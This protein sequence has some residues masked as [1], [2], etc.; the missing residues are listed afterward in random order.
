MVIEALARRDRLVTLGG[1]LLVAG[2][3]WVCLLVGVAKG[4]VV[5]T[6]PM[7][8]TLDHAATT[9]LKWWVTMM[10][11]MLP[12]AAPMILLVA[13]VHRRRQPGRPDAAVALVAAGY[14]AVWGVFSL[15]AT[16]V[17]WCLERTGLLAPSTMRAVPVLAG[18]ILLG[19][20]LYQ[21][22]PLKG[23]CLRH[24]HAPLG[25]VSAHWR[26]GPSG[27]LRLGLRHG[28]FCLGCCWPLVALLFVVGAADLFWLGAL[29]LYILAEKMLP[30]GRLISLL[31]GCALTGAGV[32]VLA[33]A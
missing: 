13:A 26:R 9:F 16:G 4:W 6:T 10:A 20:G 19:V 25:F 8:W 30:H 28:A 18:A 5:V 32:V 3:A 7:P 21:L 33:A 31:G 11:V 27:A 15:A 17:Q 22:T 24:C 12:S 23:A 1:L 2:S 14:L 29:A